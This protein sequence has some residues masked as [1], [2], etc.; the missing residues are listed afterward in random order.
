[1][2]TTSGKTHISTRTQLHIVTTMIPTRALEYAGIGFWQAFD[3]AQ[4]IVA[5]RFHSVA[6][7]L[8]AYLGVGSEGRLARALKVIDQCGS[9][10]IKAKR[11]RNDV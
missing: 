9:D 5:L 3:E 1:M 6:W 2:E 10:I 7:P 4:V 8:L 11:A